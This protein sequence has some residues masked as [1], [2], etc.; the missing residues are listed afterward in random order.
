[1]PPS[2]LSQTA[3]SELD[4]MYNVNVR[5]TFWCMHHELEMMQ[6]ARAGSIANNA[7]TSGIRGLPQHSVYSATKHAVVGLTKSAAL[8]VAA[9]GV[10]VNCLCPGPVKTE[11]YV[12]WTKNIPE[13]EQA[14]ASAVPM[15]RVADSEEIGSAAAWLLSDQASYVTGTAFAIDGGMCAA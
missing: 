4:R 12:R 5:G 2:L 9:E 11:M 1:M 8:E 13:V 7:S 15:K 10:R 14:L 6:A 3:L